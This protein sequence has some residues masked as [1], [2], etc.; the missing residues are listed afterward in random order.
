MDIQVAVDR[1]A[2]GL[3]FSGFQIFI[4]HNFIAGDA[5]RAFR[6]FVNHDTRP[7]NVNTL[8]SSVNRLGVAQIPRPATHPKRTIGGTVIRTLLPFRAIRA[9]QLSIWFQSASPLRLICPLLRH[10][11]ATEVELGR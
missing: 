9:R 3:L 1:Y 10:V 2:S 6:H 4:E 11:G 5:N 8:P 7:R